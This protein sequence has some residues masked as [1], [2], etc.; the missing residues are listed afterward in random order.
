MDRVGSTI[1]S[2]VACRSRSFWSFSRR[3][4]GRTEFP[5]GRLPTG[6]VLVACV[7]RS[8]YGLYAGVRFGQS[9]S[10][11]RKTENLVLLSRDNLGVEADLA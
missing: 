4:D 3:S 7:R 10:E 2:S 9:A 11:E 6:T 8:W 5:L 1:P